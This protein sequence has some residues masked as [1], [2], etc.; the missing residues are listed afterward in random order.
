MCQWEVRMEL[1]MGSESWTTWIEPYHD[2]TACTKEQTEPGAVGES[3][4]FKSK[5][6]PLNTLCSQMNCFPS[7]TDSHLLQK[8]AFGP[9]VEG[10]GWSYKPGLCLVP[11]KC[12]ANA[13]GNLRRDLCSRQTERVRQGKQEGQA[14]LGCGESYFGSS[15][16]AWGVWASIW[17]QIWLSGWWLSVK[18]LELSWEF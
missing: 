17:G 1:P 15:S 11:K 8:V 13:V 9:S 12:S 2:H 18:V 7:E 6:K 16:Q 10:E 4:Y 14:H 3:L 5:H